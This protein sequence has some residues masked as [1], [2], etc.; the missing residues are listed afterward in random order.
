MAWRSSAWDVRNV[1]FLFAVR[2]T[3]KKGLAVKI[4]QILPLPSDSPVKLE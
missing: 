2:F 4:M 1:V 3:S